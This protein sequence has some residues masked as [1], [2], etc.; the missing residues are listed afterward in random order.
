MEKTI[1]E[2]EERKRLE[3]HKLPLRSILK[4]QS[5]VDE[6]APIISPIVEKVIERNPNATIVVEQQEDTEKPKKV[7]RFK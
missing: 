3:S 5:Q 4:K 7:S 6:S 1:L 2:E